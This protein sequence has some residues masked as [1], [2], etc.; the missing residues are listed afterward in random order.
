MQPA[1]M[2]ARITSTEYEA[3]RVKLHIARTSP[4]DAVIVQVSTDG[5]KTWGERATVVR[6]NGQEGEMEIRHINANDGINAARYVNVSDKP[7]TV[8]F[9]QFKV[10]VPADATANV[11]AAMTDGDLASGYT[12][13]PKQSI[14][15]AL[16]APVTAANT[17]VLSVGAVEVRMESDAVVLTVGDAPATVYEIVH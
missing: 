8:T 3:G 2:P 15:V 14:R 6:G 1:P 16:A 4:C 10:D 9:R 7:V 12:L 5:G 13:E 11:V 17:K